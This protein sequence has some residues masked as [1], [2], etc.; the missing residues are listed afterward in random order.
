[1]SYKDFYNTFEP[2]SSTPNFPWW[3][4]P[5]INGLRLSLLCSAYTESN[6]RNYQEKNQLR[7]WHLEETQ[8]IITDEV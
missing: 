2:A 3:L 8:T 1:M 6:S 7:K 4:T 5:D